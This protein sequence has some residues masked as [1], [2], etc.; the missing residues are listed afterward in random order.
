M[1]PAKKDQKA[2][3][4]PKQKET[5]PLT[6]ATKK[7]VA[8]RK[9]QEASKSSRPTPSQRN[10]ARRPSDNK[11]AKRGISEKRITRS[12]AKDA[13]TKAHNSNLV[14]EDEHDADEDRSSSQVPQD[15]QDADEAPTKHKQK[16]QV[17]E[18]A[19]NSRTSR[20][21]LRTGL[22]PANTARKSVGAG[23]GR[24]LG[25]PGGSE[26]SNNE[27]PASARRVGNGHKEGVKA[28]HGRRRGAASSEES[29][30]SDDENDNGH[31]KLRDLERRLRIAEG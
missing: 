12:S 17:P 13:S 21:K 3:A 7:I 30:G 29:D 2:A 15:E 19:S 18:D 4:S 20:K 9:A 16:V 25:G 6:E 28:A 27:G 10:N 11:T 24:G 31:D 22:V 1:A 26:P 8:A 23:F 5:N 14:P